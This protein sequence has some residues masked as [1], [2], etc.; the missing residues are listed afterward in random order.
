MT[1]LDIF[2]RAKEAPGTWQVTK[3]I[4]KQDGLAGINKG[5]TATIGRNGVFNMIYFGFYHSVKDIVPQNQV[6]RPRSCDHRSFLISNSLYILFFNA[7]AI[8]YLISFLISPTKIPNNWPF[9]YKFS[10]TKDPT[11]EFFRK[12]GIGFAS[13]TIGSIANIP[14]DVAKSRIQV[15][16]HWLIHSFSDK[17]KS[18]PLGSPTDSRTSQIQVH[19]WNDSDGGA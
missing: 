11:L 15:S 19:L 17:P 16:R 9:Y 4:I 5:C 12:I 14:F 10:R 6:R 7:F 1:N 8:H 3:N 2:S 18:S 13:G